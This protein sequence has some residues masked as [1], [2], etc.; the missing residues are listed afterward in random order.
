MPPI[1]AD[2]W[3]R[4]CSRRNRSDSSK[5]HDGLE[6]R[7]LCLP[8]PQE[9]SELGLGLIGMRRFHVNYETCV[10]SDGMRNAV[11]ADQ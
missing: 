11:P 1:G 6:A 2:Y 10:V 8:G 5:L 9:E 7:V 3:I 4:R